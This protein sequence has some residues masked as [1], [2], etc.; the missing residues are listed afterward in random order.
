[1]VEGDRPLGPN[2]Q[3]PVVS[4]FSVFPGYF[5][6]MGIAMQ[7]GRDFDEHDGDKDRGIQTVEETSRKGTVNKVD[8]EVLLA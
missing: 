8:A 1:M 5:Q 4:T 7:S 3:D 6:A 2:E